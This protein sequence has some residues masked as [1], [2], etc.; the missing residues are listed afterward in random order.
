MRRISFSL[1]ISVVL[2]LSACGGSPPPTATPTDA[3]NTGFGGLM[4]TA[5]APATADPN[6]NGG[7]G[8]L[9]FTVTAVGGAEAAF[10]GR[11]S[12]A[13]NVDGSRLISVNG[14]PVTNASV[15]LS[16]PATITAGTFELAAPANSA[17]GADYL[18]ASFQDASGTYYESGVN[19]TLEITSVSPL[20][21]TFEFVASSSSNGLQVTVTGNIR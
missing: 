16:L 7:L 10:E 11:G 19:G 14:S 4:G 20:A 5:N 12:A 15:L 1:L 6:Q 3:P 17:G 18:G 13:T 8:P 21:A 2:M 9:N